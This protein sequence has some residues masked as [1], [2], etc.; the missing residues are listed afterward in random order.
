MMQLTRESV[1]ALGPCREWREGGIDRYLAGRESALLAEVLL[2]EDRNRISDADQRW[3]AAHLLIDRALAYCWMDVIVE[4]AI[5]RMLGHSGCPEW[6]EWA[7]RWL[8][9]EDR[10]A[11]AAR[12]AEAAARAAEAEAAAWTARAAEAWAWAWA[13]EAAAEGAA[14]AARATRAAEHRQQM[15]DALALLDGRCDR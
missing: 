8:S 4:R 12:A 1:L 14:E 15:E 10:T 5:R 7:A 13:A 6:E 2:D 9:G 11:R 3:L